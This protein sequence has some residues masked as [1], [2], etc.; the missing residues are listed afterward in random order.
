MF[1]SSPL[2]K[3]TTQISLTRSVDKTYCCDWRMPLGPMRGSSAW[4]SASAAS[5]GFVGFAAAAKGLLAV[6]AVVAVR[7]V[8]V[9]C[10][11]QRAKILEIRSNLCLLGQKLLTALDELQRLPENVA[12][13]LCCL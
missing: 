9:L 6:V 1:A 8:P 11:H 13:R 5:A 12:G 4:M 3:K 7:E 2:L 10:W